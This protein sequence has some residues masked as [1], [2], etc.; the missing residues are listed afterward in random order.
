MNVSARRFLEHIRYTVHLPGGQ[1]PSDKGPHG[2]LCG[3]FT[4]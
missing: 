2:R 4:F 1:D 3:L